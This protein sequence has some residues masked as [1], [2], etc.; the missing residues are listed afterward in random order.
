MDLYQSCNVS[1][2]CLSPHQ[3]LPLFLRFVLRVFEVRASPCCRLSSRASDAGSLHAVRRS[4]NM[5][6]IM[7]TTITLLKSCRISMLLDVP[8]VLSVPVR[9]RHFMKKIT[10]CKGDTRPKDPRKPVP[11]PNKYRYLPILPA[12]G[13]YT[14]RPL[15]CRHLGGR[16]PV[17]GR[18]VVRTIARGNKKNFRWIDHK[19]HAPA[20]ETIEEKVYLIRYDPLNT[21][22]IALVA[23]GGFRRWIMASENMKPGDIIRTHNIMPRNPIRVKEADAYPIGAMPPG[24]LV[25][26]LEKI[27]GEGGSEMH[28]YGACAEI[29]KRIGKMI[30]VK[31]P[32][33]AEIALDE[34]CMAVVGR[35]SNV[36]HGL[37]NLLCPQRARWKGKRPSSGLWHRKDGWCGRKCHPPKPLQ[38]FYS[39]LKIGTQKKTE[40]LDTHILSNW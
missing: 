19:R 35:G 32:W 4:V 33:K 12:D 31:M 17:T 29:G 20:G 13:R 28:F 18:V 27:V 6:R 9:E 37:I 36:D 10:G 21:F 3:Q 25:H 1:P 8:A 2:F 7:S 15:K 40:K 24:T 11:E 26:N 39:D 16:D 23:R 34:R 22:L 5:N 14:T 30:V 38:Y